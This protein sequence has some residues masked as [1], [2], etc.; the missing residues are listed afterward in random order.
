MW[1]PLATLA[2][3]SRRAGK[4]NGDEAS[5]RGVVAGLFL[6]DG[7]VPKTAVD[8]VEIGYRGVIGDRQATRVH[9]GRPWQALCLWSSE[10]VAGHA[11][12]GHPIQPGSAGENISIR[13]V[14]W[15]AWRPGE[16]VRLGEVEATIAAYA[17]P[18]FKN[19]RWFSDGDYERMSHERGDGSRLYAR[20]DR[21]GRLSVG[22]HA[23]LLAR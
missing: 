2:Q 3:E 4:R 1:T 13:G 18:C 15:S 6:S 23:V 19:A 11:A 17:I 22:D 12:Q 10:V 9:H 14:D 21:P 8:S 20:V 16:R 7:G 5:A